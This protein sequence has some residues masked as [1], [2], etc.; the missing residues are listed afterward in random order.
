MP[1]IRIVTSLLLSLAAAAAAGAATDL[2]TATQAEL[3]SI[4]GIGPTM[5]ERL[6]EERGRRPF[7]NW[8]DLTRRVDGIGARKAAQWSAQG[9]TVGGL[10]YAPAASGVAPRDPR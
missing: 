1:L 9:V 5:S 2:N 3:E 7:A 8:G 6:L 10:P 4:K